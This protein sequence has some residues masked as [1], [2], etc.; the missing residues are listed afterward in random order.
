[1]K[2]KK[3]YTLALSVLLAIVP[4]AVC[5]AADDYTALS[6]NGTEGTTANENYENLF[7]CDMT[8]K[9]CVT[10]FDMLPFK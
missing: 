2:M 7:D 1:M 4:V 10:E 6:Y 5:N 8:T 9:W 3:I